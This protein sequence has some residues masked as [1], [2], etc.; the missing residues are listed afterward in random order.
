MELQKY[1]KYKYKYLLLKK[2][3][4]S[5]TINNQQSTINNQQ[6]TDLNNIE[7]D[8]KKYYENIKNNFIDNIIK[9]FKEN[10]INNFK[11]IKWYDKNLYYIIGDEIYNKK[12]T[13]YYYFKK[14]YDKMEIN[15]L[16][17]EKYQIYYI[18]N[19]NFNNNDNL[20]NLKSFNINYKK[21]VSEKLFLEN[22]DKYHIQIIQKDEILKTYFN[23][24]FSEKKMELH[25]LKDNNLSIKL[26]EINS[27]YDVENYA[28][29]NKFIIVPKNKK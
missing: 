9:F 27:L 4:G 25:Y 20:K 8:I 18:S 6:S 23:I 26:N 15:I 7:N 17:N 24:V 5:G 28:D 29:N 19:D 13:L 3:L 21:Y 14:L 16:N 11:G 1:N 10:I 12:I 22:F 2:I